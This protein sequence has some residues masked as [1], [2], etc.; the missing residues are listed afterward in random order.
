M[1]YEKKRSKKKRK[2]GLEAKGSRTMLGYLDNYENRMDNELIIRL[3][4]RG[5]KNEYGEVKAR[6]A[7]C[8][9]WYPPSF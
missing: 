5:V 1:G 7:S 2:R 4:A 8:V 9:K 6:L 3:I